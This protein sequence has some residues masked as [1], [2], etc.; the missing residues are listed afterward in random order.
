MMLDADEIARR[1]AV[2]REARG[3]LRLSGLYQSKFGA[4]LEERWAIGELTNEQVIQELT[5]HVSRSNQQ[6]S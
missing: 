4:D 6:P 2:I 1:R 3:N 5:R